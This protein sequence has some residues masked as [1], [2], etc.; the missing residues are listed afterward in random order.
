MKKIIG[1]DLGTYNT[2][3]VYSSDNNIE[4]VKH[5]STCNH[6]KHE[7]LESTK[8]MP[9]FLF[10]DDDGTISMV[11]EDAK[12]M[13]CTKPNN[14]I[15]GLK[16]LMGK[17]WNA[18]ATNNELTRFQFTIEP[19]PENGR[20]I[21]N[22]NNHLFP[23]DALITELCKKIYSDLIESGID[24]YDE[25]VVTIPC[26]YSAFCQS[27]LINALINA[28]FEKEKIKTISEPAAA[29]IAY[30][31]NLAND[32]SYNA[33]LFDIGC[34]TTDISIGKIFKDQQTEEIKFDC[35]SMIGS[36]LGGM[37]MDD[38][39]LQIVY[40]KAG[41]EPETL[42]KNEETILRK[43]VEEAKCQLSYQKTT[44]ILLGDLE[45]KTNS[46]ILV[47]CQ[48]DLIN[49]FSAITAEC[50]DLLS[51]CLLSGKWSERDIDCF[52]LVGGPTI[53]PVF[54][55][56]F[57]DVFDT[58]ETVIAQIN[59]LYNQTNNSS[60][61]NR[62]TATGIGA[63][64]SAQVIEREVFGFGIESLRFLDGHTIEYYPE[65]L[66]PDNSFLPATS[67][68]Y[69]IPWHSSLGFYDLK[70]LQFVP[71]KNAERNNGRY[72]FI[73]V[74]KIHT[75]FPFSQLAIQMTVNSNKQL[76]TR[77][78]DLFDSNVYEFEGF[79][80]SYNEISIPYPVVRQLPENNMERINLNKAVIDTEEITSLAQDLLIKLESKKE[81]GVLPEL[82]EKLI[83]N[84]NNQLSSDERNHVT[85][86][87]QLVC[88]VH[89]SHIR[90]VLSNQEQREFETALFDYE[91]NLL[92]LGK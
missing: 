25:V 33:C 18:L 88:C 79:Q 56:L 68:P 77:I 8:E 49:V 75:R 70:I 5:H 61:I 36:R 44:S 47:F 81:K 30:G 27:E 62:M 3:V 65:I 55:N 41:I 20:C 64:M 35:L 9:S 1:I 12:K 29:A 13:I 83:A 4:F 57:L 73:G 54:K 2:L 71:D 82:I 32:R 28:G 85:L 14:V 90:G 10:I 17:T 60:K 31:L 86:F 92:N 6:S 19:D 59:S 76:V 46:D 45:T 72:Q 16:R 38:C 80:S 69:V 34:G 7:S 63:V 58:N 51:W 39:L 87:N 43:R 40:T 15:W 11:G 78:W 23:I 89:N 67:K 24:D 22:V 48:Q 42:N 26:Y 52:L 37:D 21:V 50:R 91:A 53:S 66:I 74:Y 84:V